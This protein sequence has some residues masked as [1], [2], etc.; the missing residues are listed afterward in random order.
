MVSPRHRRAPQRTSKPLELSVYDGQE[1]LG[2]ILEQGRTFKA[3]SWPNQTRLGTFPSRH[4]AAAALS[5]ANLATGANVQPPL[6][7]TDALGSVGASN[8]GGAQ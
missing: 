7:P 6:S 1:L 4:L 3:V 8:R 5:A 2:H